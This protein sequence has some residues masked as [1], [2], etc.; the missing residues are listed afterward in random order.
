M[1]VIDD[2]MGSDTFRRELGDKDNS[3]KSEWRWFDFEKY[4]KF[5]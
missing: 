3:A 2:R 5:V 1:E 4:M